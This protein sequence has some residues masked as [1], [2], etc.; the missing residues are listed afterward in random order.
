MFTAVLA[1]LLTSGCETTE[2]DIT[3]DPNFLA[4]D[5]ANTDF[6]LN[7]IQEDFV[8]HLEGDADFDIN[9]NFAS[10]GSVNGDG[11]N[12]FGQEMTRLLPIVGFNGAQN[13]VTLYQ[14]SEVA[15]E[16]ANAYTGA[17]Q[18][19]R[20]MNPL[21]EEAGQVHHIAIGQFIE[22]YIM[23]SLVDFFGDV[24]YSEAFRGEEFLLNP[25]LDPGAEVYQAALTL[26]D[27]AIANFN[28]TAVTEPTNDVF[29]GN[30]YSLWIKAI[31]TLKMKIYLQQR[32]VEPSSIAN[33]NAIV[34]SGNY[35]LDS[36]EDFQYNWPGTSASNPDARHPRYGLNYTNAGAVDW[37]SN[38]FMNLLNTTDDPR[39]RYYFYRQTNAVPGAE[40]PASQETIRCSVSPPP[41]HF[42]DGGFPFCSLPDGYW[43]RTR[44]NNFGRDPDGF[45]IATWGVYPAG[46][47]FDDDRFQGVN[48][49]QGGNGAG[50]TPILT[51]AWV[52]FMIAEVNMVENDIPA[53]R[54]AMING[55]TKSIAKVQTFSAL[56]PTGDASFAPTTAEVTSYITSIGDA[57]DAATTEGKWDI[58]GEQ[59][60][61]ACFGNGVEP[62]NFYR[63]TGYPTTG[64]PNVNPTPGDLPRSM[65]YPS[66]AVNTNSSIDQKPDQVQPVFWDNN[67][68]GPIAN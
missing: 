33:F 15:D 7:S 26:L 41:Q 28:A 24:P 18:D 21:A 55:V 13:Y 14:D 30:N 5:Q 8:R 36:S 43:G 37:M 68:T 44:G 20:L 35:I 11:L 31:N 10:G 63:R 34:A 22:A 67:P 3:T 60:L 40:I 48:P 57:W 46:G 25:K 64:E 53:A 45:L 50:I 58:W 1:V 16:W 32:L 66:N 17:L 2:L 52:D 65:Y 62:Y 39:I 56:D 23:V 9:D 59:F 42:I 54:T 12:I 47:R 4:P 6:Y 49:G 51:A 29:Y 27:S 38:W 61:T 19:I